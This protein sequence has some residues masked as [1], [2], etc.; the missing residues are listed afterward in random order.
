ME[1]SAK[2]MAEL[3]EQ[4]VHEKSRVVDAR[5]KLARE[6]ERREVVQAELDKTKQVRYTAVVRIFFVIFFC[7]GCFEYLNRQTLTGRSNF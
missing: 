2:Q 1:G 6:S 4:L 5:G 7:A 3:E